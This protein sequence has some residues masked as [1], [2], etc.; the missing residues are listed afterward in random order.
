MISGIKRA[1]VLGGGGF[2]ASAWEIGLIT[3]MAEAGIDVRDA[4]LL[5]GTSAGARVALHLASGVAL[6]ELFQRQIGPNPRPNGPPPVV[7]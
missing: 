1:L 4:G 5:V 3:G 7:D 6:E 2:A